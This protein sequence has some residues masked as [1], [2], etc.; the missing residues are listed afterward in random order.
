MSERLE[1]EKSATA[2]VGAGLDDLSAESLDHRVD[3]FHLPA[4]S[5]MTFVQMAF[6]LLSISSSRFACG[7]SAVLGRDQR[8]DSQFVAGQLVVGFAV[9]TGIRRDRSQAD[10]GL[11]FNHERSEVAKV[12]P[13]SLTGTGRQAEMTRRVADHTQLGIA[14]IAD[15]GLSPMFSDLFAPPSVV[16]AGVPRL[17]A[18]GIHGRQTHTIS[19]QLRTS[20]SLDGCCHESSKRFFDQQPIGRLLQRGE[21]RHCFQVNRRTER[22]AIRQQSDRTAVREI[23]EVLE[24]QAGKQLMQRELLRTKPMT[25]RR[26]RRLGYGERLD[27]DPL[28]TFAC[29][30]SYQYDHQ[31]SLFS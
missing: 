5:I 24:H 3:G 11:G 16:P 25:I 1:Q 14:A 28:R 29:L 4:L 2:P 27:Q 20:R 21:V 10:S 15:G 8:L 12:G 6:H 19:H 26:Q 30:H 9:E 22:I 17:E 13:W 18:A 7:R 31:R 23:V